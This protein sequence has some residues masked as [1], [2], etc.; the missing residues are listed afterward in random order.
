MNMLGRVPRARVRN[1]QVT[2][3]SSTPTSSPRLSWLPLHPP[4]SPT[5]R[6]VSVSLSG[7]QASALG[8]VRI[9]CCCQTSSQELTLMS[10]VVKTPALRNLLARRC[11]HRSITFSKHFRGTESML[12]KYRSIQTESFPPSAAQ[13]ILNKQR[14]LRPSSPHFTIYQ[15]Q[16]TWVASIAHRVAGAGISVREYL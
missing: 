2:L 7:R 15:P 16:L 9:Q 11:A 1:P 12:A 4:C 6:S 10:I 14:L 13:G 5:V 8:M 3:T